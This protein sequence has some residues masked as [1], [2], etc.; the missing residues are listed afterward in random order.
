MGKRNDHVDD[1]DESLSDV[2]FDHKLEELEN[3]VSSSPARKPIP[4]PDVKRSKKPVKGGCTSKELVVDKSD[5]DS[6]DPDEDKKRLT[7]TA[8]KPTNP[9]KSKSVS[10]DTDNGHTNSEHDNPKPIIKKTPARSGRGVA[11]VIEKK[12]PPQKRNQLLQKLHLK[13]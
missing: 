9:A 3:L 1:S 12:K 11:K 2:M 10:D 4:A 8:T 6:V 7:N 13:R 5:G